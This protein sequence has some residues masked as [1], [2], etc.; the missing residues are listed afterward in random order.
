MIENLNLNLNNLNS[1]HLLVLPTIAFAG[2]IR[3]RMSST[4]KKYSR[5]NNQ[6]GLTGRDAAAQML[7]MHNVTDVPIKQVAGAYTDH[8]AHGRAKDGTKIKYIS[9][10]APVFDKTTVTAVAV[11]AHEAGHALQ[12]ATN[13]KLMGLRS[14]IRPV[15]SFGSRFGPYLAMAGLFLNFGFLLDLGIFLFAGAVL[16]SL[17]TLPAELNASSRALTI[18]RD[19]QMLTKEELVGAK[20]ALNAAA[21][22]Y[23]ASLLTNCASFLRLLLLRNRR[24]RR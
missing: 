22:T 15:S 20:K 18:L 23:F 11:A 8:Y 5:V 7:K 19:N 4:L 6:K 17:L 16:F 14:F 9:L 21:M 1:Y 10:S 12:Y 13:Y 24:R 2:L 3:M